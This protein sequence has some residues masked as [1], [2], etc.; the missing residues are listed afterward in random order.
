MICRRLPEELLPSPG[1][2]VPVA[3]EDDM[4]PGFGEGRG[5]QRE[6]KLGCVF[7][8]SAR[9]LKAA[10]SSLL[11]EDGK[12]DAQGRLPKLVK[13]IELCALADQELNDVI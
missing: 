12:G 2:Q 8:V 1:G 13:G 7:M 6:E 9:N 10:S 5:A 3:L 4:D 11:G